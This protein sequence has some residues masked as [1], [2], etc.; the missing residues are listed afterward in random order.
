VLALGLTGPLLL[1]A[2]FAWRFELGADA[3]S[4]L[5]HLL[6]LGYVPLP[7]IA[8]ALAWFAAAG[9]LAAV[10]A[11]RYAPYPSARERPPRGPIRQLVRSVLLRFLSR[12]RVDELRR[13]AGS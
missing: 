2:S 11:G 8:I 10:S 6:A 5:V 1:L 9:Q 3:P 12:Q 4:Y 7:S 13:A